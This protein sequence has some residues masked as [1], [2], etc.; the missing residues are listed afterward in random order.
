MQSTRN[1]VISPLYLPWEILDVGNGV[2]ICSV[3]AMY[4]SL[5]VLA[6]RGVE[7]TIPE[8]NTCT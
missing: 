3:E 2:S 5:E 4:E 1:T 6:L 8:Q 7:G